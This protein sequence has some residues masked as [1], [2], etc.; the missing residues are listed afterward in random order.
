MRKIIMLSL[1]IVLILLSGCSQ[2]TEEVIG[3]QIEQ[4]K[5][6]LV[7]TIF[8][9]ADLAREIGGDEVAV[10]SLLPPGASPHTFEPTPREM[11]VVSQA[12]VL[13]S[14]GAGLDLWGQKLMRTTG[15]D[16]RELVVTETLDLLPL[17][18]HE[19]GD[20]DPHVWLDP[21]LV[22][23]EIAPKIAETM[24]AQWPELAPIFQKNLMDF[25]AEL[26]ELDLELEAFS[27]SFRENKFIS[28][29]ATWGYLAQRYGLWEIASVLEYP[30]Q[31]PSAQWLKDL[32]DLA[33]TEGVKIIFIEPQFNPRPAEILADELGGQVF[34]LDPLGGEAVPGRDSYMRLMNYNLNVLKEAL[35]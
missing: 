32:T 27:S 18:G 28:F 25:Q 29:H 30:G 21:Y 24:A 19:H 2:G 26:A 6:I 15:V 23:E 9:L 14:V 10:I 11:R 20:G 33:K 3:E 7:A 35:Q 34:I 22:K 1:L 8:P 17:I 16:L 12:Q 4:K 13:V 5:P 31:E